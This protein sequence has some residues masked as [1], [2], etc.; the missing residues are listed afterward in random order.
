[1][2]DL[3]KKIIVLQIQIAPSRLQLA[4]ARCFLAAMIL[5]SAP[6][7]ARMRN[8]LPADLA[9]QNIGVPSRPQRKICDY[10][11]KADT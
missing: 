10:N 2:K 3:I 11:Q 1:M 8:T 4:N 9:Y 7:F 5:P 6:G